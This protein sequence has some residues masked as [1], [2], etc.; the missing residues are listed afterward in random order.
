M[1][2]FTIHSPLMVFDTVHRRTGTILRNCLF[3]N[4]KAENLEIEIRYDFAEHSWVQIYGVAPRGS[5]PQN[6]GGLMLHPGENQ[7]LLSLN[8]DN[9]NFPDHSFKGRITFLD[10]GEVAS[11]ESIE[12]NFEDVQDLEPFQGYAAIDLGTN[13]ILSI[14]EIHQV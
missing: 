6:G 2:S 5:P 13:L 14:N 11:R 4:Q 8:T 3:T 12:I 10:K 9:F 7:V 1:Q